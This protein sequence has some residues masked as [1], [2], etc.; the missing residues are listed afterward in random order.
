MNSPAPVHVVMMWKALRHLV[1][2]IW[3]AKIAQSEQCILDIEKRPGRWAGALI[4]K[5]RSGLAVI[6]VGRGFCVVIGRNF[7]NRLALGVEEGHATFRNFDLDI[8]F[9][10]HITEQAGRGDKVVDG[11]TALVAGD[12]ARPIDIVDLLFHG[13]PWALLAVKL[14]RKAPEA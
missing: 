11:E 9:F 3:R 2:R 14:A 13:L 8:A 12:L 10:V 1:A 7:V 6:G 5:S 4:L